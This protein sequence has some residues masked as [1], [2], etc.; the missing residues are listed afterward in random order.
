MVAV[1]R[2][3]LLLLPAADRDGGPLHQDLHHRQGYHRK[4]QQS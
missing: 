1:V 2:D 3:H 4:G